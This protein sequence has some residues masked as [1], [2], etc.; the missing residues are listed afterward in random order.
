[1]LYLL[2]SHF[3]SSQRLQNPLPLLMLDV[4]PLQVV[5]LA[6][7]LSYLPLDNTSNISLGFLSFS[8]EVKL[9]IDM[10]GA[11]MMYGI[12]CKCYASLLVAHDGCWSFLHISHIHQNLPKPNRF[13]RAMASGHVLHLRR[14]QCNGWLFLAFPRNDSNAKKKYVDRWSFASPTQSASQNPLKAISLPP[15]HNLK[16]KV[17]F[18]Y[19]MIHLMAI[20]C[21]GPVFDM[22]WLTVLTANAILAF[23]ATIAYMRDPTLALY[24]TPSIF[25]CTFPNSSS[26]SFSNF[27]FKSNG[28]PTGLHFF[29][30]KR[31]GPLCCSFFGS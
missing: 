24:G 7:P 23:V 15:R 25:L 14:R 29:M 6:H 12:I 1:M 8:N 30:L 10:F 21:S 2:H 26:K 28:V 11:I 13:L 31:L 4:Y 18:K 5:W 20:Q 17:L 3:A 19:L 27:K 22:D 9:Y 16:S